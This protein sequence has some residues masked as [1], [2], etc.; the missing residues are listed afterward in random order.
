MKDMKTMN[1]K[2]NKTDTAKSISQKRKKRDRG[3]NV[4]VIV[5]IAVMIALVIATVFIVKAVRNGS[6][7]G[8]DDGGGTYTTASMKTEGDFVYYEGESGEI[9]IKK[10]NGSAKRVEIPESINGK[11]VIYIFDDAF[12]KNESVEEIVLPSGIKEILDG[13]FDGC[14][15]LRTITLHAGI[16]GIGKNSFRGCESLSEVKFCG[17]AEQYSDMIRGVMTG[18]EKLTAITPIYVS[19]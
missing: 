1:K 8:G 4:A 16:E 11:S 19:E 6:D 9:A 13:V 12:S 17:T 10:Y 3:G 18:N 15:N 7:D 5:T 14:K 2:K